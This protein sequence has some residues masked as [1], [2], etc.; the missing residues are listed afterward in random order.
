M[1][2]YIFIYVYTYIL[3]HTF[4]TTILI[5]LYTFIHTYYQCCSRHMHVSMYLFANICLCA[6]TLPITTIITLYNLIIIK[7]V[8]L[9]ATY[10][11]KQMLI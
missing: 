5:I 10:I 3:T 11:H 4:A 1:Y 9:L 7:N 2:I 6:C 8:Q